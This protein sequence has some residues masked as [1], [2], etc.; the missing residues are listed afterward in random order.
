MNGTNLQ[1]NIDTLLYPF[2]LYTDSRTHGY[3]GPSRYVRLSRVT[4]TGGGS[5]I[6]KS[7]DGRRCVVSGK[8]CT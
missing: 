6:A 4:S 1:L 8:E 3:Q 5:A 2:E 7:E